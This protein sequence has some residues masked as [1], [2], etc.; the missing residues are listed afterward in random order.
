MSADDGYGRPVAIVI[1]SGDVGIGDQV[2]EGGEIGVV[3][4]FPV[5]ART[6]WPWAVRCC[7]RSR[8]AAS[9]KPLYPSQLSRAS[10]RYFDGTSD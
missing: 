7:L 3:G 2:R 8:S 5:I 6:L 10:E 9:E 4:A 1:G